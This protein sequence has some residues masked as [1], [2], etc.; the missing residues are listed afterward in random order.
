MQGEQV[1]CRQ[2]HRVN[3]GGRFCAGGLGCSGCQGLCRWFAAGTREGGAV[4]G[5]MVMSMSGQDDTEHT[6]SSREHIIRL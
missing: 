3:A 2:V 5:S 4:P 1:V 6:G